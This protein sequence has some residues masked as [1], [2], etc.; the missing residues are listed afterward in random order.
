MAMVQKR[1]ADISGQ[2]QSV[3]SRVLAVA[4]ALKQQ[5][6]HS[7]DHDTRAGLVTISL[8]GS[9]LLGSAQPVKVG[10]ES[11]L[12]ATLTFTVSSGEIGA[13]RALTYGS[14]GSLTSYRYDKSPSGTFYGVDVRGKH[15]GLD[16]HQ[17]VLESPGQPTRLSDKGWRPSFE[18]LGW[19]GALV[20]LGVGAAVAGIP[21]GVVTWGADP[22]WTIG[23]GAAICGFLGGG[24]TE[25][26]G[27]FFAGA[28]GVGA[29][30]AAGVY[31]GLWGLGGVA[32]AGGLAGA[33]LDGTSEGRVRK[34][35]YLA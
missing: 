25:H 12:E 17:T 24:A 15:S 13:M 2:V 16:R 27:G 20:G 1:E 26:A 21:L 33:L 8:E 4:E 35:P 7:Q 3:R 29:L 28:V 34:P 11:V 6:G 30:A 31:G 10:S 23:I 5:D 14:D 18:D 22:L 32:L 19:R 9:S